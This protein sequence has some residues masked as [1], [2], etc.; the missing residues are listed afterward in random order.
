MTEKSNRDG[1]LHG[2]ERR[3]ATKRKLAEKY[4]KQDKRPIDGRGDGRR[5]ARKRVNK[6]T[7]A[8]LATFHCPNCGHAV[9]ED[10]IRLRQGF[11]ECRPCGTRFCKDDVYDPFDYE[12][13]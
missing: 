8:D 1:E 12:S 9:A 7:Q 5:L 2:Q 13:I 6:I 10:L 11:Y 3:R 4:R